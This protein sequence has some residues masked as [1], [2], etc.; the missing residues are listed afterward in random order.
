MLCRSTRAEHPGPEAHGDD[1]IRTREYTEK[2]SG[3]K[4]APVKKAITEIR[5]FVINRLDR[6]AKGEGTAA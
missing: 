3:K 6:P 5:V 4:A 1:A 2:P